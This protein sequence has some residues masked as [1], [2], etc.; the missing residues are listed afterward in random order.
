ML[1]SLLISHQLKNESD[2]A[3]PDWQQPVFRFETC[4]RQILVTSADW[5]TGTSPR[6]LQGAAAYRLLLEVLCGLHSPVLGETEVLGQFRSQSEQFLAAAR[7]PGYFFHPLIQQLNQDVKAIRQRYLGNLG[8]QSYGSLCRRLLQSTGELA[9]IGSG[10]LVEAIIPWLDNGQRPITLYS[11]NPA[12]RRLW[13]A[14]YPQIQCRSFATGSAANLPNSGLIIAAPV[15]DDALMH[16]LGDRNYCIIIDL[17]EA[18]D[19]TSPLPGTTRQYWSLQECWQQLQD[20][21]S[22]AER[23]RQR[24]RR[25]TAARAEQTL[26]RIHHR[27]F[28]WEDLCA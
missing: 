18:V 16:W 20:Q 11:R 3:E 9:V 6:Q 12:R 23:L 2:K 22:A 8:S 1:D 24:L 15:T 17:R 19:S 28:G 21:S 27:P 10:Q 4:L 14:R 5:Q 26:N 13:L 25:V 7:H